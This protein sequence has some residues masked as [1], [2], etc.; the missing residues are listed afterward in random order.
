M[1]TVTLAEAG[2]IALAS[3]ND[4]QA[5]VIADVITVNPMFQVLPFAEI[6]G[7]AVQYNRENALG[8]AQVLGVGGTITAKGAAT[9]TQKTASLTTIIGDAEVNGLVART[10]SDLNDQASVQVSS[11]AKSV[12]RLYQSMLFNGDSA[13]PNQFDGMSKLVS[14]AQTLAPDDADGEPLSFEL[15]DNLIDIVTSK[16]VADFIVME[17][18]AYA[19]LR[20]LLRGANGTAAEWITM[21][22]SRVLTYG[23]IPVF[24][25][26]WIPADEVTG[27]SLQTTSIYAGTLDDGSFTQ[28]LIG[29]TAAGMSAGIDV[30]AIGKAE[31][32]D[33]DIYRVKWYAGL[34]NPSEKGLAR[35]KGIKVGPA[36]T[37]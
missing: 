34:A 8:D 26:D 30:E 18:L 31:G 11:K 28:G 20:T 35:L 10:M 7:S 27:V 5:G 13:T 2:K 17:R 37:P 24:R 22:A 14:V 12:G 21:G 19:Q 33:N 15:L 29:I 16:E 25:S 4:L 23:G 6:N 1:A 3:G 9:F 36:V 32:A